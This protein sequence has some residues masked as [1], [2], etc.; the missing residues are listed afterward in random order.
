[1]LASSFRNV[2]KHGFSSSQLT[3]GPSRRRKDGSLA[4]E[5]MYPFIK[6]GIL[7]SLPSSENSSEKYSASI[8]R[9]LISVSWTR[10]THSSQANSKL[11]PACS[12]L[13]L[14]PSLRSSSISS[15]GLKRK[16]PKLPKSVSPT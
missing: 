9:R 3:N 13:Y 12:F 16:K 5:G 14:A 1:K 11:G 8:S 10:E 15:G 6:S 2:W 7:R 4:R